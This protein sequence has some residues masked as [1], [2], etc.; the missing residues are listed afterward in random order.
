MLQQPDGE[1][2]EGVDV[3]PVMFLSEFKK[4]WPCEV[5]VQPAWAAKLSWWAHYS[6]LLWTKKE[7]QGL[8]RTLVV[9]HCPV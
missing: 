3:S 6:V 1:V 4:G 8:P 2:V 9:H 7:S 5:R